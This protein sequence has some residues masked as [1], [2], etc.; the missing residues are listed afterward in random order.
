MKKFYSCLDNSSILA[1]PQPIQHQVIANYAQQLNGQVVFYTSEDHYTLRTQEV[2]Q[3]KL[4]QNP[5]ID[6]IIF[7]RVSQFF[8]KELNFNLLKSI[9]RSGY[10]VHFC[11]ERISIS[12]EAEAEALF[13]ML[14]TLQ[15][16]NSRDTTHQ[17]YWPLLDNLNSSGL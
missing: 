15:F 8:Y 17:Y 9:L 2:I 4:K 10:E 16:V 6:G 7:Y 13:P 5:K 3:E 12:T 11:R 1:A 14:K